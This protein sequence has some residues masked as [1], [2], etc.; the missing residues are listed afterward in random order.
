MTTQVKRRRGTTAQ[1]AAFTGAL[2]ELTVDTDLFTVVVH[3]GAT[4]G[5]FRLLAGHNNLAELTSPELARDNIGLGNVDNTADVDKPV[6]TAQASAIATAVAD[7][8][9]VK[10]DTLVSGTNIKT[11]NGQSILGTGNLLIGGAPT[12][13]VAF[14]AMSDAPDGWLKAN[15]AA[16]S[17]TVYSELFAAIGTTYGEGDGS[18]TF[19]LPDLRGEFVRGLDDGR[20]VDS[21]RALGTAQQDA[22]QGHTHNTKTSVSGAAGSAVQIPNNGGVS[23]NNGGVIN[24]DGVNGTPRTA[25]ETRP[26][27]VAMLACIKY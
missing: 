10:Q 25:A 11:V 12:G 20:G 14:F 27:N 17:R 8:A 19:N 13:T 3:D 18:T 16:V 2:A 5:G 24:A 6:S 9:A 26:R 1:H 23:Y 7:L 22:M 4:P 15:G 21:G